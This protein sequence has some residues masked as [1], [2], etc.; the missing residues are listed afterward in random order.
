MFENYT[1]D[2]LL[3]LSWNFQKENLLSPKQIETIVEETKNL[4]I[5]TEYLD[6][7]RNRGASKVEKYLLYD[8]NRKPFW[9]TWKARK[10]LKE[11][12]RLNFEKWL[13]FDVVIDRLNAPKIISHY[14]I[15]RLQ[16]QLWS[17]IP[18]A[19]PDQ[20]DIYYVFRT[21]KGDCEYISAFTVHC[22]KKAGY[23]AY[24]WR[25][26][27]PH[28]KCGWH[29]VAVYSDNGKKMVIDNGFTNPFKIG[30][31]PYSVFKEE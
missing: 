29:A 2:K 8:F 4:K 14:G 31:V 7:Y 21:K 12:H 17:E 19:V 16:Y 28:S 27:T 15:R 20:T 24:L 30:I 23:D 10:I 26:P 11:A 5:K 18:G 22:L 9:F 1:I 6:A 13:E 3:N 25:R